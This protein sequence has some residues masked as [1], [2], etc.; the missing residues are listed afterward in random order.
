M[1]VSILHSFLGDKM[2]DFDTDTPAGRKKL[3]EMLNKLLKSGTAIFLERAEKTYRVTGW[4][5]ETDRLLIQNPGRWPT[6]EAKRIEEE[7]IDTTV[8]GAA[9]QLPE[10]TEAPKAKT[11]RKGKRYGPYRAGVRRGRMTAIAPTA[12]G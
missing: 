6:G 7:A 3:G 9:P 5:S 1:Q 10:T 11:S 8:V 12:G 4:D 2:T